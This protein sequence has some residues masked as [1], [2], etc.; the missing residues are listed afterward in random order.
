MKL[1]FNYYRKKLLL[2]YKTIPLSVLLNKSHK[3]KNNGGVYL[4]FNK[5]TLYPYI[6]ESNNVIKR[7]KQHANVDNPTQYIDREIRKLGADEFFVAFVMK[8]NDFTLRREAEKKYVKLFNS[9]YNGYNGSKDGHPMN[10]S[11]RYRQRKRNRWK[12][13]HLSKYILNHQ[14]YKGWYRMYKFIKNSQI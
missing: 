9:Y 11:Q 6:G 5:H 12:K 10:P 3:T 14:K 1:L 8:E 2:S 4:I 7:L 13:K